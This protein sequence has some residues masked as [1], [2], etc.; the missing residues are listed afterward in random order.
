M[1]FKVNHLLGELHALTETAMTSGAISV[2]M[3][4]VTG[5]LLRDGRDL[6]LKKGKGWF[7]EA[8]TKE[9]AME[10]IQLAL[11][12]LLQKTEKASVFFISQFVPILTDPFDSDS[13]SQLQGMG[14]TVVPS[15]PVT[16]LILYIR[17]LGAVPRD[18][19]QSKATK[20]PFISTAAYT[21]LGAATRFYPQK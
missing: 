7:L 10:F 19:A 21:T 13:F 6:I 8:P 17:R 14:S 18:Q 12:D 20:E 11:G 5:A 16:A 2:A 3:G 9:E 1:Q 15:R 4:S